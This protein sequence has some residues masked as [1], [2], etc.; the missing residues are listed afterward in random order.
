M[1]KKYYKLLDAANLMGIK[2]RTARQWLKDGR[3]NAIKYPNS[4]R[5]YVEEAEILRIRGELQDDNENRE[6]S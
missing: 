4:N 2:I 3:L 6:Y 1:A 5:W